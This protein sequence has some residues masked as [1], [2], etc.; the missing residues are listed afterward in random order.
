MHKELSF[1]GEQLHYDISVGYY[2]YA[3]SSRGRVRFST[4]ED[5][6]ED[7]FKLK[8]GT[9]NWQRI[10]R[11]L[12]ERRAVFEAACQKAFNRNPDSKEIILITQDFS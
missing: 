3:N 11:F 6:L 10:L 4:T 2:L 9:L 1:D 12:A 8:N 7:I 5:V